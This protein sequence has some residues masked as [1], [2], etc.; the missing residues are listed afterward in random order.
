[1]RLESLFPFVLAQDGMQA[2]PSVPSTGGAPASGA[3]A[4]GT[5]VAPSSGQSSTGG[6]ASQ[7]P[8]GL[9]SY[10]FPIVLGLMVFYLFTMGG[11][12]RKDRKKR[13][14]MLAALKKGDRV[15]IIGGEIGS[16]VEVR[17]KDI[18]LKV[19]EGN[20]TRIRYARDAIKEVL[21][22]KPE[23]SVVETK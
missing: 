21:V 16:V 7:Q 11:S 17:D 15:Q 10:I 5:T 4:G 20:N 3:P 23:T 1:M 13:E 19:D 8:P 14:A 12:G 9:S 2:A 18:L 6:A 22:D